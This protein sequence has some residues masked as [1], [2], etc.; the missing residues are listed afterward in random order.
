MFSHPCFRVIVVFAALCTTTGMC[1]LFGADTPSAAPADTAKDANALSR[2]LAVLERDLT[3]RD[4]LDVLSTM[5]PTDLAA[6]WQRVATPDNYY[7]FAERHGGVEKLSADPALKAAYERRQ[8]IAKGFLDLMRETYKKKNIRP[9]FDDDGILTKALASGANRGARGNR[10][11]APIRAILPATGAEKHWPCFR[12]PTGQGIV[13][14][15]AIPERW[16]D[17][18]NVLWKTKLP[19]RGN[20]SPIVWGDRLFVTSEAEPR[21]ATANLGPKDRAP[22]R[23]LLCYALAATKSAAGDQVA[24]GELLWRIAAPQPKEHETLYWKNTLA[25][26]T[27]VTDGERVIAF[28]GNAGLLCTDMD[29][30]QLWHTDLGTFPTM[31]GPGTSPVLYQNLVIVIQ[32]QTVGTSLCAAFDKQTGEKVWQQP[33]RNSAGWSSPVLLRVGNRDELVYNGSHEVVAYDPRS[34]EELWKAAGTSIESIPN[35]VS[36]GGLLYS[37]S[38]RNGPIFALQPG[39]SGDITDT[40]VVWRHEHGGPHVPTPAW[41]DGRLYIVSDTGVVTCLDAATGETLSQTRLRGRFSTAPLVIGDK[42]L[43]INE[44]GVCYVAKSGPRV[45]ILAKNDLKESVLATPAVIGGRL[46]FRTAEH[47]VCIGE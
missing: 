20:S 24:P 14:D 11:S 35:I 10:S 47:L 16:S 45:E 36:G 29:G 5:I 34:G 18:K 38:G 7:L 43:L 42:L 33:R 13:F 22:Q 15:T 8:A 30:R 17:V 39:G 25:S 41:H 9:P 12:G 44:E 6:E 27:P 32:D 37:A 28:F 19:G 21:D 3:S 31:H 46:Y 2:S 40:H 4:Y 1:R 23:L 26:S